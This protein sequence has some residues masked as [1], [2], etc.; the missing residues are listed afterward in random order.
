MAFKCKLSEDMR[1]RLQTVGRALSESDVPI[2]LSDRTSTS[3]DQVFLSPQVPWAENESEWWL[4]ISVLRD[5]E[6]AHVRYTSRKVWE[7]YVEWSGKVHQEFLKDR[8]RGYPS[9]VVCK[10]V[11]NII[12]D[13]RVERA[14]AAEYPGTA[15]RISFSNFRAYEAMPCLEGVKAVMAA[16]WCLVMIGDI[17]PNLKLTRKEY[18]LVMRCESYLERG[19]EAATS[20]EAAKYA[21]R[22]LSILRPYV[23]EKYE[24]YAQM[25]ED[26]KAASNDP[27]PAPRGLKDPLLR[28]RSKTYRPPEPDEE[29]EPEKKHE[30][31]TEAEKSEKHDAAEQGSEQPEREELG[32][33]EDQEPPES[34]PDDSSGDEAVEEE[35]VKNE[36]VEDATAGDRDDEPVESNDWSAEEDPVEDEPSEDG[37]DDWPVGDGDYSE[38]EPE[39]WPEEEPEGWSAGDDP[40]NDDPSELA[41]DEPVESPEAGFG[42]ESSEGLAGDDGDSGPGDEQEY[43]GMPEP[44]ASEDDSWDDSL[45]MEDRSAFIDSGDCEGFAGGNPF[46]EVGDEF[47][48]P[49]YDIDGEPW[50]GEEDD[51]TVFE[52]RF[53]QALEEASHE[54][55]ELKEE[56][57]RR[58]AV[59]SRSEG[60]ALEVG[61]H[62]GIN[63][64]EL[65]TPEEI[66]SVVG[67]S[68]KPDK[69]ERYNIL[70]VTYRPQIAQLSREIKEALVF[71]KT[72]PE[73]RLR[74]GRTDPGNLWRVAVGETNVFR[75]IKKE[76]TRPDIVFSLL[77]DASGSMSGFGEKRAKVALT[78]SAEALKR[79]NIPFSATAFNTTY[80]KNTVL[81]MIFKDF[82]GDML[83]SIDS[84]CGFCENRDGYSIR[85]VT[86]QLLSRPEK[87][88]VLVVLSDGL[89]SHLH[90]TAQCSY[91]GETAFQDTVLAVREAQRAGV[92]VIGIYF[93]DTDHPFYVAM[94]RRIYPNFVHCEAEALPSALGAVL[95]RVLRAVH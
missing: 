86:R 48:D 30:E 78:I 63:L 71:R 1:R 26:V 77:I 5:H 33:G 28:R 55:Q 21:V 44:E 39:N 52:E 91:N 45:E 14:W 9:S 17:S 87:V 12:E 34:V 29:S 93:G 83:P 66:A 19:R 51:E 67:C 23:V 40:V 61:I 37:P 49:D 89:P 43:W 31:N 62:E 3:F 4:G 94:A 65:S 6:Y 54:L 80:V 7:T 73:R 42:E 10:D 36:P 90:T 72:L 8:R 22:V 38:E 35:Q 2:V 11:F 18:D 46:A 56:E 68:R 64:L 84:Y 20:G 57:E 88:K 85:V 81:H 95:K 59:E 82:D 13:A 69:L 41:K 74:R 24:E 60:K 79:N 47:D 32:G 70:C 92:L 15:S 58:L 25:F 76:G 50:S 27:R 53:Q 16:L 75:K